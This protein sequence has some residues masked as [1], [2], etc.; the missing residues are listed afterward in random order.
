MRLLLVILLFITSICQAQLKVEE[1]MY[2]EMR[3]RELFL[4]VNSRLI[5]SP[6]LNIEANSTLLEWID[7][8]LNED[9]VFK[10]KPGYM[11]ISNLWDI[12]DRKS[13][14]LIDL[15]LRFTPPTLIV[16]NAINND[17]FNHILGSSEM[18][19]SMYTITFNDGSQK[20]IYLALFR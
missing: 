17:V 3:V 6:E 16:Y 15:I 8:F 10:A 7:V 9:A 19:I 5:D 12:K 13:N 14:K 11:T 1:N 18:G 20:E 2:G 4:R